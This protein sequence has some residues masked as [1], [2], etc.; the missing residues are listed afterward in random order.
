MKNIPDKTAEEVK[1]HNLCSIN[2][3]SR[4]IAPFMR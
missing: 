4:K 1:T 3:F 2:F